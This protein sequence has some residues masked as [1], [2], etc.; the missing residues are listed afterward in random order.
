M[1]MVWPEWFIRKVRQ[2]MAN[3][4]VTRKCT[5]AVPD[6][7]HI[8]EPPPVRQFGVRL[9]LSGAPVLPLAGFPPGK[10]RIRERPGEAI[11][12]Y[13]RPPQGGCIRYYVREE[14]GKWVPAFINA[15]NTV[16]ESM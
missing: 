4:P 8:P 14:N 13:V 1:G 10:I 2:E 6:M 12:A 9:V 15:Q 16:R 7:P 11:V 5:G 3:D